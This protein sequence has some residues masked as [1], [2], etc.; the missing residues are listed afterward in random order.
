N[1]LDRTADGLATGNV[2]TGALTYTGNAGKDSGGVLPVAVTL[3]RHEGITAVVT[4][5]GAEIQGDFG[6]LHINPDGSYVYAREADHLFDLNGPKAGAEDFFTYT[7]TD[8]N[9][10]TTTATLIIELQ[11][12]ATLTF[13]KASNTLVGTAFDDS[14]VAHDDLH[15]FDGGAGQDHMI[16]AGGNSTL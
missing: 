8:K 15:K 3:I 11:P 4:A 5:G 12:E 16:G 2:I 7:I 14:I 13:D 9:N 10:V 6:I 1:D